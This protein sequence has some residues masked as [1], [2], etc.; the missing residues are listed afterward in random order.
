MNTARQIA[1]ALCA[2]LEYLYCEDDE[3]VRAS[4]ALSKLKP[5]AC[6]Q[7]VCRGL[8]RCLSAGSEVLF[9]VTWFGELVNFAAI[10]VLFA[11][12]LEGT[13][14]TSSVQLSCAAKNARD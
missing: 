1:E 5:N 12:E 3:V 13:Q 11:V 4:I 14:Q 6:W 7:I 10:A 2:P 9:S 8:V